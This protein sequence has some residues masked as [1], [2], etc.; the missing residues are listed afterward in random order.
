MISH[1]YT[2]ICDDLRREDNAKLL[3]VGLYTGVIGLPQL[4]FTM[5]L[6]FAMF[7]DFDTVGHHSIKFR[8]QHLETG[9]SLTEGRGGFFSQQPGLAAAPIKFLVQF[10]TAGVY[11]F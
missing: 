9:R 7:L 11:N 6:T 10:D 2:L 8:L 3:V 1:K 4:P 5:P